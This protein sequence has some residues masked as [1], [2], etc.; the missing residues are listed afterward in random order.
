ML[1]AIPG[2]SLIA[3][4]SNYWRSRIRQWQCS[5]PQ[6][7]A[8]EGASAD[9]LTFH[10]VYWSSLKS[11]YVLLMS[12]CPGLST[13]TCQHRADDLVITLP[14]LEQ[15][16][17]RRGSGVAGALQIQGQ[18]EWAW[19]SWAGPNVEVESLLHHW[20]IG[21]YFE[22]LA[23]GHKLLAHCWQVNAHCPVLLGRF[24]MGGEE[25]AIAKKRWDWEVIAMHLGGW[26][27][28]EEVIEKSGS[29]NFR[30]IVVCNSPVTLCLQVTTHMIQIVKSYF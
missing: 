19:T 13:E 30:L 15:L 21:S 8:C 16:P 28:V 26:R 20:I 12:S 25:D 17:V 7:L 4:G 2:Y 3:D 23:G 14:V 11:W 10:C 5:L 22:E 29:L 6:G 18:A 9:S 24:R 1:L 27:L